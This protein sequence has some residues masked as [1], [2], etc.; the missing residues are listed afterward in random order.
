MRAYIGK[1]LAQ[2]ALRV[3]GRLRFP[4]IAGAFAIREELRAF[5]LVALLDVAID[6]EPDAIGAGTYSRSV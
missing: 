1:T 5:A 4:L 3:D 6:G 2:D